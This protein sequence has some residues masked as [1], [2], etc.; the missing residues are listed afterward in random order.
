MHNFCILVGNLTF[1]NIYLYIYI[2]FAVKLEKPSISLVSPH[3]MV[4]YSPDKVSVTRGSTFSVTC[5]IHSIYSRGF[6]SLTNLNTNNTETMSAFGYSVL[7][8]ATFELPSVDF[9][10]QGSYTCHYSVNISAMSFSS[11]P[12]RNL[13]ISVTCKI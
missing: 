1:S 2:L 12:S 13:Y 5:S 9:K 7:Y 6:F 4:V 8:L 3:A 11:A 10:D